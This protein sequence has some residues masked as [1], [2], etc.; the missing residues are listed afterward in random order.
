MAS[1]DVVGR[2]TFFSNRWWIVAASVIGSS[3]GPGTTVIFVINVFMVPVTTELGWSRGL[4]SSGLL[5]SA[6]AG[7]IMTPIFGY[8]MDRFGIHRVALP[9]IFLYALGLASFALL[10]KDSVW[11]L[12]VMFIAASGFGACFGPIIYSKSIT[13]WF[14]KERGLALGIA[15]SGVGLGTFIVP[16]YAQYFIT[17]YGWRTAYVAVAALTWLLAFSMVA[18]FV[19]EPS[20]YSEQGGEAPSDPVSPPHTFGVPAAT[21][22]KTY[23]FWLLVIIFLAEGTANN[24]ILSGHFVPML[25]D[26]GYAPAAAAA[27]LGI[28][29]LA[30]LAA[31]VVIGFCLDW[32]NGPIFSAAAMMLPALGVAL[33]VSHAYAPAPL[34]AAICCG[35]AIGAEVD[36]LGFFTSRYFG[37]ASFG[38]IYGLI[39]AAFVCGVGLGPT[40][41]GFGFDHYHS[42]D[43]VLW[44]YLMVLIVAALLF[45]P[46]GRYTYPKGKA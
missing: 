28:S 11:P 12:Y 9:T 24:G 15:T 39:F 36:M 44:A 26:R 43:P 41:L 45:L 4:F 30:A 22:A 19:R 35:L 29:G 46:L 37:R 14:D 18:L 8:L 1:S 5:A 3:V 13:A 42:Y 23:R 27:I 38:T 33:L 10:Q 16:S 34:L 21:A 32:V 31:R 17:H 7:P 25:V 6:V 20:Q 2:S 40:I